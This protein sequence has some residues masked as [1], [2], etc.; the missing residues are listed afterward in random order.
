VYVS[1][2]D[3]RSDVILAAATTLF[4]WFAVSILA[5]LPFYP[6]RGLVGLVLQVVWVFV[7][8]G[9]VPWLLAR[10]RGDGL[11]AFGLDGPRSAWR[12][13]LVLAAPVVALGVLREVVLGRELGPGTVA[14]AVLGRIGGARGPS[15]ALVDGPALTLDAVFQAL[16]FVALTAGAILLV[17]FL[18]VRGR[19][20]FR[21]TDVSLTELLRTFGMGAA[22]VALV[23]GL[24]RSLVA[25]PPLT[26]LLQVVALG[27]IVLLADRLVPVGPTTTRTA[28]LTPVIVVVVAHVLAAGG[29]FR[30]DL[31][32]GLYTGALGAGTAAVV[33]VLVVSRTRAWAVVPLLVALHW[34]PSCLS[35]L[36]FDVSAAFC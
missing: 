10:Y 22:A 9:L 26:V 21:P 23:L 35:P 7:L 25:A 4:G 12:A 31:L 19:E 17:P 27:A 18:A 33:A 34:W 20:A 36:T 13:G 1:A 3:S 30:G 15:P 29:I 24:V 5:Q 28:V 2:E 14:G 32:T 11:A 6:R 16:L 8:T